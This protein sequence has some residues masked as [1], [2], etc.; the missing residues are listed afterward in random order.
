MRMEELT[1]EEFQERVDQNILVIVPIGATE[2]HGIHLPLGTDTFQ[3]QMVADCLAKRIGALVAPALPYGNHSST[4]NMPGTVNLQFDTLRALMRDILFSLADHGV[5]RI[6]L[7]SG[8]AGSAHMIALRE[9]AKELV[10]HRPVKVMLLTDYD[11]A[12]EYASRC[13]VDPHDGHGGAIETAR[14]MAIRPDCVR[15]RMVKGEFVD[16]GYLVLPD[17][18]RCFPQGMAGDPRMAN[19]EMG[20][21]M[22]QYV[23][24][25]L[26]EI[27]EK[28][29]RSED[30]S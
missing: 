8:H 26:A 17:P 28:E 18:E 10:T 27:I 6:L 1:A 11:L 16:P 22:N 2:A 25:R 9:A 13:E 15:A 3:P 19:A 4:R 7:L 29:M 23:V 20:E 30:E 21:K 5:K 14:M 12:R 24:D